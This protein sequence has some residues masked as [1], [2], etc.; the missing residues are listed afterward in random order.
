MLAVTCSNSPPR[1]GGCEVQGWVPD[2]WTTLHRGLIPGRYNIN[3]LLAEQKT[4]QTEFGKSLP[5]RKSSPC[6][7]SISSNSAMNEWLFYLEPIIKYK[8]YTI[9]KSRWCTLHA[10]QQAD[11]QL[12]GG[13]DS[14][15][16]PWDKENIGGMELSSWANMLSCPV[17]SASFYQN[18][19]ITE[20]GEEDLKLLS[21]FKVKI[22]KQVC[23]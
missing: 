7:T 21:K 23:Q 14:G 17:Y 6:S 12:C 13:L 20:C 10:R 8:N 4:S 19:E 2:W 9:R 16:R 11:D 5:E 15:Q 18:K 3:K 1:G 22:G